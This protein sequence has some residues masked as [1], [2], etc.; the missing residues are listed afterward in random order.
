MSFSWFVIMDFQV[1]GGIS[2]YH[3]SFPFHTTRLAQDQNPLLK[4]QCKVMNV[5][6]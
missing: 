3:L 6:Q 5:E 1:S 2:I 4:N